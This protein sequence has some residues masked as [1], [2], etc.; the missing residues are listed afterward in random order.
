MTPTHTRPRLVTHRLRATV[1]EGLTEYWV[2]RAGDQELLL[3]VS[4]SR[5]IAWRSISEMS[6][7][8]LAPEYIVDGGRGS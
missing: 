8:T 7:E 2:D 6:Y 1:I 5:C 4:G 3:P